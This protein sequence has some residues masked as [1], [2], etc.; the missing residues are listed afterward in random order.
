M[1]EAQQSG[2]ISYSYVFWKNTLELDPRDGVGCKKETK[3]KM[4][5]FLR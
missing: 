1:R 5:T 2:S 3:G 4:K